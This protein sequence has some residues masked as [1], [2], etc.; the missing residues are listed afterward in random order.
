MSIRFLRAARTELQEAIAYYESQASNLGA[1][2]LLEV[3]SA[4]D[5]ISEF[6]AAWQTV[7]N[8]IRRCQLSRFPFA[9][10]YAKEGPDIVILSVAH[11]HRRPERWRDRLKRKR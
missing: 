3:V 4:A 11:L 5:R 8:A 1:I 7:D 10:I 6:P 9:L 2:F